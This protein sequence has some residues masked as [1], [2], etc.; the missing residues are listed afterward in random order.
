V[1]DER[2]LVQ[3]GQGAQRVRV[4]R[5]VELAGQRGH[6]QPAAHADP[7]VDLPHRQVDVHA[8]QSLAPGD[9]VLVDRVDQRPVEVEQERGTAPALDR[10]VRHDD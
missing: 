9:H 2:L 5:P 3:T 8:R 4:E 7:A 1:A 10:H 6:E